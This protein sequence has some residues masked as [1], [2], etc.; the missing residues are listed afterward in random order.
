MNSLGSK[1][2]IILQNHG[3]LTVGPTVETAA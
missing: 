2:A 3:L 1:K